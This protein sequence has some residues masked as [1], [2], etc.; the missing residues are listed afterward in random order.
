MT[1]KKVVDQP[2][3]NILLDLFVVGQHLGGVLDAALLGTDVTPAQY[4]VY[5]QLS[6]N[7]QTPGQLCATLGLRPATL[8]GYLRAM[9]RRRDV[10]RTRAET[11]G[12]SYT[13]ALT[14]SG[15]ARVETCRPRFRRAVRLVEQYLSEGEGRL[16]TQQALVQLD[17]ALLAAAARLSADHAPPPPTT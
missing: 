7:P 16:D 5:T 15:R 9:E 2:G 1:R 12:R 4:A 3:G 13:I 8:S 17:D 10:T 14:K 6:R 11:D